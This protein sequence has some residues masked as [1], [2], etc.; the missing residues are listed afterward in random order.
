[1]KT[2]KSISLKDDIFQNSIPDDGIIYSGLDAIGYSG[3]IP[4]E[5]L[6]DLLIVSRYR[7]LSMDIESPSKYIKS[8]IDIINSYKITHWVKDTIKLFG[9]LSRKYNLRILNACAIAG[10]VPNLDTINKSFNYKFNIK[11]I[12]DSI[13]TFLKISDKQLNE[14]EQLPE[15]LITILTL[16]SGAGNFIK[17][18]IGYT[19]TKAQMRNYS[20]V[21]RI[22]KNKFAD[23]LFEYKLATKKYKINSEVT[24]FTESDRLVVGFFLNNFSPELPALMMLKLLGTILLHMVEKLSKV[25]VVV[26]SFFDDIYDK[27]IITSVEDIIRNFSNTFQLKLFPINNSNALDIMISE[28]HGADVVFAVNNKANCFLKTKNSGVRVNLISSKSSKFNVNYSNVCK[29]TNGTFL[30]I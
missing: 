25:N 3:F 7:L 6:T 26:Y 8:L 21:V 13:V 17:T 2:F 20:D 15:E 16:S 27:M 12:P 11:N 29:Q 10:E 22:P 23:P 5:F 28:N 24:T 18:S 9:K 19:T 1:M 4:K 30:T 14:I